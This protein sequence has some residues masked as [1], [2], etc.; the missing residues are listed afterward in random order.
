MIEGWQFAVPDLSLDG[1]LTGPDNK[2]RGGA[3]AN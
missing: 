2:V 1:D 3:R